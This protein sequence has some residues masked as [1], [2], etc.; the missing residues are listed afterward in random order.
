MRL[1]G[2]SAQVKRPESSDS[3][4]FGC[5]A[6]RK[7]FSAGSNRHPF[8]N[9]WNFDLHFEYFE[10]VLTFEAYPDIVAGNLHVLGNHGNEFSLQ[11]RQIIGGCM[12]ARSD[13]KST[14]L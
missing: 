5:Y 9:R 4:L 7:T 3:G 12:S 13:R 2:A 10:I 8:S 14:R 6:P 11:R 1:R